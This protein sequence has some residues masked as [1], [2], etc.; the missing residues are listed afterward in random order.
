MVRG[1]QKRIVYLKS[2]GSEVF[3]DAYFVVRDEALANI[4][5]CDMVKE[6]NRILDECISLDEGHSHGRIVL[7]FIK[8][9]IIPF[10]CG[11]A[12]GITI[13]ILIK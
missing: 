1:C 10:T 8:R 3:S 5:E 6:A 9:K 4:G 7:N 11:M 2:T 13:A 12:L